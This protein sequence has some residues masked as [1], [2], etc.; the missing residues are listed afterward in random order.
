MPT[1]PTSFF[2]FFPDMNQDHPRGLSYDLCVN[3]KSGSTAI[4]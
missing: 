1:F 3:L 2:F 4:S